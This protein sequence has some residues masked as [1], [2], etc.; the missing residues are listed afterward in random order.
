MTPLSSRALRSPVPRRAVLAAAAG[1][2]V[3]AGC[4]HRDRRQAAPYVVQPDPPTPAPPPPPVEAVQGQL[5]STHTRVVGAG[6]SA[7]WEPH[8]P[9]GRWDRTPGGI[10]VWV[11]VA[12][13]L[14]P[15]R[16]GQLLAEV[17]ATEPEADTRIAPGTRLPPGTRVIPLPGPFWVNDGTWAS[18]VALTGA[19]WNA[20]TRTASDVVFGAWRSNQSEPRL[21]PVL[22]HEWRHLLTGDAMAGHPGGCCSR[23]GVAP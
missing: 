22:A 20:D 17:D 13:D 4:N 2:L 12:V 7:E 16:A 3:A 21:L 8:A 10:H 9:P 6:W 5:V 1:G 19:W 18:G 11:P 23:W 15:G 14:V